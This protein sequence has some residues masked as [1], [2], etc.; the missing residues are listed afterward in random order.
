ML[1][2]SGLSGIREKQM[3]VSRLDETEVVMESLHSRRPLDEETYS[4]VGVLAERLEMVKK[5]NPLFSNITFSP[6]IEQMAVA[7]GV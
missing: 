5:T 2:I 4:A 3:S 1:R 7:G 6:Q